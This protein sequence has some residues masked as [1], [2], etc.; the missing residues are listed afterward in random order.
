MCRFCNEAKSPLAGSGAD[1]EMASGFGDLQAEFPLTAYQIPD[2]PSTG[3]VIQV[4]G[5]RVE[6]LDYAGD[7]DW[8][9]LDLAA[10]QTVQISLDGVGGD[11]LSDPYLRLYDS[12]AGLLAFNDDGGPGLNSRLVFTA[13]RAGSYFI[14]VDSFIGGYAG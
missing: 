2:N 7:E 1:A 14:E 13:D 9:R 11:A 8:F 3:A 6:R 10:G 5:T 12:D 4:G